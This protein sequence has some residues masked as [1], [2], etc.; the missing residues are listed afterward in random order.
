MR[1]E[2]T[3]KH[4]KIVFDD[5]LKERRTKTNSGATRLMTPNIPWMWDRL[6]SEQAP[7]G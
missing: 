4:Q 7:R 6:R 3:D 1:H 2:Y 5:V